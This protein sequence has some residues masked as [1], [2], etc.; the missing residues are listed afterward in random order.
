MIR[1]I[2]SER[3]ELNF[4]QVDTAEGDSLVYVSGQ[5]IRD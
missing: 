5:R 1:L 4:G 2:E 3:A